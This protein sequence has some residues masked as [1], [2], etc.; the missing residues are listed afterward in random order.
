MKNEKR[1][2]E[3]IAFLQGILGN[4]LPIGKQEKRLKTR[5][6]VKGECAVGC[7]F[8]LPTNFNSSNENL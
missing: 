6:R 8:G 5:A 4:K 2:E 1:K 7:S 3:E